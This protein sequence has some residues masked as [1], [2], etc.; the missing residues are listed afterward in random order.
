MKCITKYDSEQVQIEYWPL[1]CH[2]SNPP[3]DVAQEIVCS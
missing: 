2:T 1:L 3:A